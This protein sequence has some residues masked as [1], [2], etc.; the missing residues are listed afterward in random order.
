MYDIKNSP[1]D[2][3]KLAFIEALEYVKE[4]E[5][6][7]QFRNEDLAV[8]CTERMI[9]NKVR[10]KKKLNDEMDFIIDKIKNAKDA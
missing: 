5:R 1:R 8:K 9:T 7:H 2:D 10:K 3:M 6:G 4:Q